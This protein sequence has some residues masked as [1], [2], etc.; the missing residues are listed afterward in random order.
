ME[1]K[2]GVPP[3]ASPGTRDNAH[4]LPPVS[5]HFPSNLE[6]GAQREGRVTRSA[7]T[8]GRPLYTVNR[9]IGQGRGGAG[10]GPTH[11]REGAA[12]EAACGGRGRAEGE[13][14][15]GGRR[16]GNVVERASYKRLEKH[17]IFKKKTCRSG[18]L[19]CLK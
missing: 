14:R 10:A 16:R 8:M 1:E 12:A 15:D 5:Q 18:H 6:A 4:I 7:S 3:I 11:T 2:L 13:A 9:H 17:P 19:V